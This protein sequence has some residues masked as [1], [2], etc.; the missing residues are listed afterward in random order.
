MSEGEMIDLIAENR[1]TIEHRDGAPTHLRW[2]VRQ[3]SRHLATGTSLRRALREA[4]KELRGANE[5]TPI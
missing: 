1:L 2:L 4:A 3:A 5:R